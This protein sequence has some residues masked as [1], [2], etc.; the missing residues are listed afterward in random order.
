MWIWPFLRVRNS[1]QILRWQRLRQTRLK[2]STKMRSATQ[3]EQ[4]SCSLRSF[5]RGKQHFL[6][7]MGLMIILNIIFCCRLSSRNTT[8]ET[9]FESFSAKAS[10]NQMTK[11]MT[12]WNKKNFRL[13]TALH[14]LGQRLA[15]RLHAGGWKSKKDVNFSR[16][17]LGA[18]AKK[19]HKFPGCQIIFFCKLMYKHMYIMYINIDMWKD[20]LKYFL[21]S[22]GLK[23]IRLEMH[24]LKFYYHLVTFF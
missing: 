4:S 24:W 23:Y 9:I 15:A 16:V 5:F 7:C 8:P 13:S 3:Q 20:F 6:I 1:K 21:D 17:V 18:W 22:A 19:F 2:L 14:Y 12:C 11:R 10:A